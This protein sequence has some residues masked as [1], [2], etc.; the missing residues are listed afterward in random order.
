MRYVIYL[1]RRADGYVLDALLGP[2]ALD[3][4]IREHREGR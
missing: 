1:L 3:R 4:I 2:D